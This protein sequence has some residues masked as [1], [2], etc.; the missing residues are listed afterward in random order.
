MRGEIEE[1]RPREQEIRAFADYGGRE[2]GL[3]SFLNAGESEEN[4]LREQEICV[5]ADYGGR[6]SGFSP[7]FLG[8]CLTISPEKVIIRVSEGKEM[9]NLN[10][11]INEGMTDKEFQAVLEAI[12]GYAQETQS[13]EK[14]IALIERMQGKE[15]EPTSHTK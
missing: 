15:K 7:L 12:K 4:S 6:E 13:I 14:T 10:E 11:E 9:E 1:N 3:S 8:Q 2:G 5:F